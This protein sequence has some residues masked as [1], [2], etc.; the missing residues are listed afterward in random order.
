VLTSS[1]RFY[2]QFA[3][4]SDDLKP[5]VESLYEVNKVVSIRGFLLA[6]FVGCQCLADIC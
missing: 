1:L 3:L 5:L 4:R 6:A 2:I